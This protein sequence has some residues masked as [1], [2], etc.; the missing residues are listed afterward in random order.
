MGTHS[1]PGSTAYWVF[2]WGL[3]LALPSLLLAL[4]NMF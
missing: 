3:L 4:R 2:H 1:D